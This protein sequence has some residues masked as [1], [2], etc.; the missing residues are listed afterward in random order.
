M[1][2]SHKPHPCFLHTDAGFEYTYLCVLQI[3]ATKWIEYILLAILTQSLAGN[4]LQ[5]FASP[6][7]IDTVVPV[8]TGLSDQ[9]LL[10]SFEIAWFKFIQVAFFTPFLDT[11][12]EELNWHMA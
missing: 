3:L 5:Y 9:R 12:I 2:S 10:I 4:L 8:L 7:N 11:L 1:H 6:V